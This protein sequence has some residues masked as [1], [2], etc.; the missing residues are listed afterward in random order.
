MLTF[1]DSSPEKSQHIEIS[2]NLRRIEEKLGIL[3]HEFE[4]MKAKF[5]V[6]K[7]EHRLLKEHLIN[8][9][10]QIGSHIQDALRNLWK[11]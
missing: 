3:V 11:P 6:L 1:T 10:N 9:P 2:G 4:V 8:L 5:A 7:E